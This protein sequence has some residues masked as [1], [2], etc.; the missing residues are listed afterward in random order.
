MPNAG[1]RW[2]PAGMLLPRAPPIFPLLPPFPGARGL[3]GGEYWIGAW[4]W[5][6][7]SSSPCCSPISGFS[8]FRLSLAAGTYDRTT[9][10]AV[11]VILSPASRVWRSAIKAETA[12]RQKQTLF[13]CLGQGRSQGLAE[14]EAGDGGGRYQIN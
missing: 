13:F 11:G 12:F 6:L 3:T 9:A 10:V 4:R 1:A 7:R 8:R 14:A 5:L 2:A